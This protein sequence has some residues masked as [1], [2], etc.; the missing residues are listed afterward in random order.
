M[1]VNFNNIELAQEQWR[2]IEGYDGMYQVSD[3]GRVR[4]RKSGE[5]KVLRGRNNGTGYLLVSLYRNGKQKQSYIH[6]LVASAFIPNDDDTKNQINHIDECKQNNRVSNLEYC[7]AQYNMT[8]NN[9][10]FRKKNSKRLKI[11]DLY[12]PNL[13]I[14]DN[15]EI[16]RANGIECSKRTVVHLRRDL[17]LDK[18]KTKRDEIRP[19]YNPELSINEN[20]KTF[21]EQGIE[22]SRN[23]VKRLRRELGLTKQIE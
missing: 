19:L 9:L 11:K 6:R 8:Y 21:K 20:I 15:L 17:K 5:W 7:T 18:P 13:S 22:C 3:I 4:S 12:N 1:K 2:D 23:T 10:P 14:D 16:F